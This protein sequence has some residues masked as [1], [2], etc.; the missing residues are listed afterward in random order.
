MSWYSSLTI[1][2]DSFRNLHSGNITQ[3]TIGSD[4]FRDFHPEYIM[5]EREYILKTYSSDSTFIQ[6]L[7]WHFRKSPMPILQISSI[8]ADGY[9]TLSGFSRSQVLVVWRFMNNF[10]LLWCWRKL[11]I[12]P[13]IRI[14]N[15]LD[16]I[17][18]PLGFSRL[19]IG[20]HSLLA[21]RRRVSKYFSSF[22][23]E[24]SLLRCI[25]TAKMP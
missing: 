9:I 17:S 25:L 21:R 18:P 8:V 4:Y 1:S 15:C 10:Q 13:S 5:Q 7:N 22:R 3:E 16:D 19:K 11:I 6:I 23:I 20:N 14:S 2:S 12:T 24:N